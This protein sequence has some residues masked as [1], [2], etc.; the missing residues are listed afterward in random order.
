MGQRYGI[1]AG[2]V[3]L[4]IQVLLAAEAEARRPH[5]SDHRPAIV[6]IGSAHRARDVRDA[7][8]GHPSVPR[9]GE[10]APPT[11]L[12]LIDPATGA[13]SM[14]ALRRDLQAELAYGP[15]E[16]GRPSV[17]AIRVERDPAAASSQDDVMRALVE[18]VPF[19]VRGRDRVYRTG[20]DEVALLMPATGEEGADVAL[21]RLLEN[22][23]LVLADRKLGWVRLA[24]RRIATEGRE[25][26]AGATT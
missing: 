24:P 26:A 17:V 9:L 16:R 3:L 8:A 25:A 5:A 19:M 23:P 11:D 22:V 7:M 20:P 18:V 14:K 12:G 15:S 6:P 1:E 4:S 13:G 2:D 21:G 10:I